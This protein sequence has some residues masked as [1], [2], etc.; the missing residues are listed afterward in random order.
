M[1]SL[2]ALSFTHV[3]LQ[4]VMS[5]LQRALTNPRCVKSQSQTKT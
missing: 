5:Y 1:F 4:T 2:G 3:Q